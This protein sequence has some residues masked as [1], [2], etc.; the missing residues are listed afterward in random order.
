MSPKIGT[1]SRIGSSP[2]EV[3][4]NETPRSRYII[5]NVGPS[6]ENRKHQGQP[7]SAALTSNSRYTTK[8]RLGGTSVRLQEC[9]TKR[10]SIRTASLPQVRLH[11][12]HKHKQRIRHLPDHSAVSE[13]NISEESLAAGTR[14]DLLPAASNSRRRGGYA[15]KIRVQKACAARAPT[16]TAL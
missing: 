11:S 7:Q 14:Q 9:A 6:R 8:A 2:N 3:G 5:T 1:N 4:G 10:A 15:R 12:W 16:F 13:T